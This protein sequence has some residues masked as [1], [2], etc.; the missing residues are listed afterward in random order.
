MKNIIRNSKLFSALFVATLFVGLATIAPV[1]AQ[2]AP[3][4]VFNNGTGIDGV[5]DESNFLRI[6]DANGAN[7]ATACTDGQTVDLWFYVHNTNPTIMNGTNFDG[8]GVAHD[9]KVDIDFKNT[10]YVNSH[11]I[12]ASVKA[13]NSALAVDNAFI[14]CGDKKIAIE[15]V[16]QSLTTNA[17]AASSPYALTGSI[18][19]NATLGYDGG[20]VPGCFEYRAY[21]KVTVKVVVQPVPKTPTYTCD[22][23]VLA[24]VDRKAN[25]SFRPNGQ[26]GATFKDATV[27]YNADGVNKETSV[28]NSVNAE[29]KIASSHTFG[30]KDKNVEAVATVRFNVTEN[31]AVTVKE[32]ECKDSKVLGVKT[33]PTVVK[34]KPTTLPKTGAGDIAG[35]LAVVTVAGAFAHRQYTLKRNR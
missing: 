17:P 32:V 14:D 5:G 22:E 29:G 23:F 21:I 24:F 27:K 2:T 7:T 11:E 31:N 35:I 30:D 19:N 20:V 3:D 6:N 10:G 15:Y 18:M 33:P 25:V 8:A 16:S 12:Q 4:V 1:N 26:N 13:E 9:T 34:P 28:F